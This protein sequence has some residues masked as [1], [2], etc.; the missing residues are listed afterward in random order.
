MVSEKKEESRMS[1]FL[2]IKNIGRG[3]GWGKLV[4]F[5]GHVS[6]GVQ[7]AGGS[8]GLESRKGV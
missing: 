2:E 1:S 3:T 4:S 5:F 8:E 7:W 6:R